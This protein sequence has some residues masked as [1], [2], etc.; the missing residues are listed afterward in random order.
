MSV[1]NREIDNTRKKIEELG[2]FCVKYGIDK[3]DLQE[4]ASKKIREDRKSKQSRKDGC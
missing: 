3:V 1:T 2:M 4:I